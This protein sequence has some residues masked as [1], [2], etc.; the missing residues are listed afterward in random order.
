MQTNEAGMKLIKGFEGLAPARLPCVRLKCLDNRLR[1][2]QA[3]RNAGQV[4]TEAEADQLLREDLRE[5]EKGVLDALGGA[6]TTGNQF[7][8]QWFRLGIQHRARRVSP[9]KGSSFPQSGQ[10]N[11]SRPCLRQLEQGG[12]QGFAWS[13][14]TTCSGGKAI[15]DARL[16]SPA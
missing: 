9:V 10:D 1:A 15:F 16:K 4:I 12:R 2:H 11:G 14:A 13:G 5:F 6:P 8:A 3:Q 7:S